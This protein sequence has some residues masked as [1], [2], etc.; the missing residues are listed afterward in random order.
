MRVELEK[1][2]RLRRGQELL[3]DKKNCYLSANCGDGADIID[4]L[5]DLRVERDELRAL[6]EV[7]RKDIELLRWRARPD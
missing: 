5:L 3:T 2:I 6:V 4:D 7:L 1:L